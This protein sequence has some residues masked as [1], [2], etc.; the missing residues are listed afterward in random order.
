MDRNTNSCRS[1]PVSGTPRESPSGDW[2]ETGILREVEQL[3]RAKNQEISNLAAKNEEIEAE[4]LHLRDFAAEDARLDAL[5][6]TIHCK[7]GV[8]DQLRLKLQ[9]KDAETK[10]K[11]AWI[12]AE[13]ASVDKL[14][15]EAKKNEA[16]LI[17]YNEIKIA[18]HAFIEEMKMGGGDGQRRDG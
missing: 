9:T 6:A 13:L 8:I 5:T 3:L 11:Q 7:D 17:K 2:L 1:E 16:D 18:H 14:R 12:E 10:R 4:N 15:S